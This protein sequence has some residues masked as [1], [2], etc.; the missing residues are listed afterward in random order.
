MQHACERPTLIHRTWDLLINMLQDLDK[1]LHAAEHP[2]VWMEGCSWGCGCV[3]MG[4]GLLLQ[5]RH[6]DVLQNPLRN[7][8]IDLLFCLCIHGYSLPRWSNQNLSATF[9]MQRSIPV[10]LYNLISAPI[11]NLG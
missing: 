2:R 5:K 9:D 6:E 4:K 11:R 7:P 1:L 8:C 10:V 3:C